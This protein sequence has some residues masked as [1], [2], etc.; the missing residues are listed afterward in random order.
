[1]LVLWWTLVTSSRLFDELGG[2]VSL[3]S[4]PSE[5]GLNFRRA[6][7]SRICGSCHIPLSEDRMRSYVLFTIEDRVVE[8]VVGACLLV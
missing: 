5:V 1:M 2:I 8:V 7:G 4:Y 3:S 6:L